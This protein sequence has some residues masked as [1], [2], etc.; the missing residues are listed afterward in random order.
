MNRKVISAAVAVAMTATMSSFALPANAAEVKT[1]QYQTN[2]RQMEK[3]NRGLIAVK[4]TADTRG[5]AVNGVYLSWRLLGDESLENQAFDIYKNGTKIHTT[6]VHD[7]TNWIDTSGTASDKYKVVKAGEDASK[8]TEV[9]PTSNNNCAKS[10]EVGNGNSEKNSFTY[11]DIPI[12]RPDPVER[13]GDGK[14][15]N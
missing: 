5:Q 1:P 8:E 15:S 12:S 7:A 6:G 4:T 11:V 14:I 2:A 10:N 13:M 9:T 3:L